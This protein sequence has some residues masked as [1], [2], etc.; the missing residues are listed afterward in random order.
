MSGVSSPQTNDAQCDRLVVVKSKFSQRGS[1][2]RTD[3][4][5]FGLGAAGGLGGCRRGAVVVRAVR[6]V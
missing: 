6:G 3:A 5:V 4:A 2:H 1:D